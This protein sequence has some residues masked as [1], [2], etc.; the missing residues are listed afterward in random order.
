MT[1]T[2]MYTSD[3]VQYVVILYNYDIVGIMHRVT[4][5]ARQVAIATLT[6]NYYF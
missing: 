5:D 6:H 4:L 1:V 2:Y 3:H